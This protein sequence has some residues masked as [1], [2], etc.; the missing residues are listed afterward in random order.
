M[1][2]NQLAVTMLMT[3]ETTYTMTATHQAHDRILQRPT[4]TT[5]VT[6]PSSSKMPPKTAASPP[7]SPAPATPTIT[8]TA[9]R[10][11]PRTMKPSPARNDRIAIIATPIVR[12]GAIGAPYIP[13]GAIGGGIVPAGAAIDNLWAASG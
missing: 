11:S 10:P 13:G 8:P 12:F 1:R 2:P 9:M 5:R 4:A 7:S 3:I 6:I